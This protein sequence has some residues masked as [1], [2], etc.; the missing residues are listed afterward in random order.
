MKKINFMLIALVS[1][2][3]TSCESS[4]IDGNVIVEQIN[5]NNQQNC[6]D[7]YQY[8]VKLKSRGSDS[9]YYTNYRYEVGDTLFSKSELRDGRLKVIEKRDRALDSL[10]QLNLKLSSKIEELEMYNK[11]LVGIIK[12]SSK[13]TLIE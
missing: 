10:R 1:I 4:K 9:Y 2:L 3:I 5:D 12:E 13:T 8:Q 11:L 7:C 6:S